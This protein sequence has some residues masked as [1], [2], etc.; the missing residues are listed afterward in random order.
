M[1]RTYESI[2]SRESEIEQP[3]VSENLY[4]PAAPT[5]QIYL[6]FYDRCLFDEVR[7]ALPND[8]DFPAELLRNRAQARVKR[9]EFIRAARH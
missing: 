6:R 2:V 1:G 5:V 8:D 7:F 3:S 9:V 4:D